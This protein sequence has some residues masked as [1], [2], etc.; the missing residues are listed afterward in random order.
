AHV[1]RGTLVLDPFVGTGS[2]LISASYY[3]ATCVGSDIDIR[4]L[5]GYSVAYLNPHIKHPPNGKTYGW[6][7]FERKR[8]EAKKSE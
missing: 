6:P 7:G 4:V 5:K 2:I 1:K 3:G 8:E